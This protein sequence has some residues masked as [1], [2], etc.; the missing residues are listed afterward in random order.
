MN[1]LSHKDKIC[2]AVEDG[3]QMVQHAFE[4]KITTF[5][6]PVQS[7]DTDVDEFLRYCKGKVLNLLKKKLDDLRA[8]KVQLELFG[9]YFQPLGEKE[10]TKS[11]NTKSVVISGHYESDNIVS[12]LYDVMKTKASEF[13]HKESGKAT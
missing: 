11:F 2:I 9:L 13:E 4:R 8:V 3:V 5:R 7:S 1:S 6:I 10:E 12:T